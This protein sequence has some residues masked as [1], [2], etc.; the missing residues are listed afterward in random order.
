MADVR[1]MK[2]QAP[3]FGPTSLWGIVTEKERLVDVDGGGGGAFRPSGCNQLRPV[4]LLARRGGALAL[5]Q[6]IWFRRLQADSLPAER[7]RARD[8]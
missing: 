2:I 1:A 4:A 6:R 7:T 3:E 8:F 5:V